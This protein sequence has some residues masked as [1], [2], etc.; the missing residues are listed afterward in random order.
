MNQIRELFLP[1]SS[2]DNFEFKELEP[3]EDSCD[4]KTT[5]EQLHK[6]LSK[7]PPIE[8]Q[9]IFLTFVA[10]KHRSEIARILHKDEPFV[11][12][13]QNSSIKRLRILAMLSVIDEQEMKQTFKKHL[14]S[15]QTYLLLAYFK[16]HGSIYKHTSLKQ[17]TLR[18]QLTQAIHQLY[19]LP[20]QELKRY[21]DIFRLLQQHHSLYSGNRKIHHTIFC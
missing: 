5:Q 9:V 15:R 13:A 10:N 18:Y 1:P 4:L 8:Q 3:T 6:L 21:Q 2:F 16:Y 11:R 14:T 7:L 12:R 20:Y 19:N 17:T